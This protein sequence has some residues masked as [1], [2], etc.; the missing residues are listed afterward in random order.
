MSVSYKQTAALLAIFLIMGSIVGYSVAFL[1]SKS[2]IDSLTIDLNEKEEEIDSLK[3][4]A[5]ERAI[6]IADLSSHFDELSVMYSQLEVKWFKLDED[7]E[8]LKLAL[9]DRLERLQL[10]IDLLFAIFKLLNS[11]Y[12]KMTGYIRNWE[13]ISN[14]SVGIVDD[15]EIYIPEIISLLERFEDHLSN[16]PSGREGG[17]QTR[18]ELA[19]IVQYMLGIY[20][21]M[22]DY[23]SLLNAFEREYVEAVMSDLKTTVEL[24]E[25]VVEHED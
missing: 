13:E 25:L 16:A 19:E 17:E 4:I 24:S 22:S 12:I 18:E 10:D 15:A 8:T 21:Y 3:R 2:T 14:K 6:E 7:H 20:I 5:S 11:R 9:S 1:S 23:M